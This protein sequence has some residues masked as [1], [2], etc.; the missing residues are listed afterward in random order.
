MN[1]IKKKVRKHKKNNTL[2]QQLRIEEKETGGQQIAI[3]F[4]AMSKVHKKPRVVEG[5]YRF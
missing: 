4:S 2:A 1:V 3:I 5:H